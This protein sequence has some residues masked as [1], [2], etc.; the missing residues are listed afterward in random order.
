M[1]A[2][3]KGPMDAVSQSITDLM[4][5]LKAECMKN[6]IA[7]FS[8]FKVPE[9]VSKNGYIYDGIM[10]SAW[11]TDDDDCKQLKNHLLIANGIKID[12]D[13]HSILPGIGI[14]VTDEVS[15]YIEN[16]PEMP[17]IS[18]EI[19]DSG[20]K[21]EKTTENPVKDKEG[22]E[23]FTKAAVEKENPADKDIQSEDT[24]NKEYKKGK[25]IIVKPAEKRAP[26]TK[27]KVVNASENSEIQEDTSLKEEKISE[28][29][30]EKEQDVKNTP[31]DTAVMEKESVK[32]R[33]ARKSRKPAT[34]KTDN[35]KQSPDEKEE[36]PMIMFDGDLM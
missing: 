7:Y 35:D 21:Q 30:S 4:N 17:E 13:G 2:R 25:K 34:E 23:S 32:K 16:I 36:H 6:H 3:N 5:G 27:K 15:D 8:A 10:P 9:T 24:D 1:G 26:K 12:K 22:K 20:E 14:A 29:G 11:S 31:V 28:T 18:E 19:F 33:T